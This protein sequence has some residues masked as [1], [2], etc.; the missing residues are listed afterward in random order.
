VELNAVPTGARVTVAVIG[1][2]G[3]GSV[4]DELITAELHA[5]DTVSRSVGLGLVALPV[6]SI[7]KVLFVEVNV[8]LVPGTKTAVPLRA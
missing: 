1:P 3:R 2:G 6:T 4:A 5:T 8:V 7:R